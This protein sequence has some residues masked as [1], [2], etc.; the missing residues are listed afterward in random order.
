MQTLSDKLRLVEHLATTVAERLFRQFFVERINLHVTHSIGLPGRVNQPS[1]ATLRLLL[2]LL[3]SVGLLA[4]LVW[5]VDPREL[6][7]QLPAAQPGWLIASLALAIANRILMGLK[8]NI[9]V[10]ALGVPLSWSDSVKAY[11]A[12]SFAGIFLPATVGADTVRTFI[13]SKSHGNTSRIIS[14]I[15]AERLIGL[16]VLAG[17]AFLGVL[18]VINLYGT[19]IPLSASAGLA[20]AVVAISLLI[21]CW[22]VTTPLFTRL[23]SGVVRNFESR[24]GR[25]T[26]LGAVLGEIRTSLVLYRDQPAALA[27]FFALTSLENLVAIVRAWFVALAFGV[28]IGVVLFFLITPI[29]Q[30]AS[31]LPISFNGLG[32]REGLFTYALMLVGNAP[33][34]GLA[35]GL[36]NHL[37]FIVAILPGIWFLAAG[38]R[39]ETQPTRG[40]ETRLP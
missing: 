13:V 3:I 29:E 1:R 10:R 39:P 16:I 25:W 28:D 18:V 23:I 32:I 26:R 14:S 30:F 4:L 5:I 7:R 34:T 24:G 9:L 6:G 40:A 27:A 38:R 31:R 33:A 15:I 19:V 11:F 35:V 17:F 8:W 2:K 22:F 21:G 36:V 20:I 37:L 12:A